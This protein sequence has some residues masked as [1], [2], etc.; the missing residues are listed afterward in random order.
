MQSLMESNW[1]WY[2]ETTVVA[3]YTTTKEKGILT[4]VD[5]FEVDIMVEGH[6]FRPGNWVGKMLERRKANAI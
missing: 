4:A 5:G 1:R 2:G 6:R 3:A